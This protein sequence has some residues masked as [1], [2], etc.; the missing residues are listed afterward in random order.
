MLSFSLTDDGEERFRDGE[1]YVLVSLRTD[2]TDIG[3]PATTPERA[4]YVTTVT[5]AEVEMFMPTLVQAAVQRTAGV[6]TT[7]E[8]TSASILSEGPSGHPGGS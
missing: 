5:D 4:P 2:C 3:D 6:T 1:D 7:S 8:S